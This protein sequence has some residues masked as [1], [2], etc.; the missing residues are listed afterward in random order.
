MAKVGMHVICEIQRRGAA[1]QLDNIAL[2]RER[3]HKV[4]EQFAADTFQK[5][6]L[7]GVCGIRGRKQAPRPLDLA[8]VL[9][10]ARAAFL[11]LPVRRATELS[12]LMHL[13]CANLHLH[14][15]TSWVE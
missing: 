15:F 3:I 4:T 9:S 8:L 14:S 2:R 1:R 7:G 12:L 13:A 6:Q 5:I 10:V 11:V